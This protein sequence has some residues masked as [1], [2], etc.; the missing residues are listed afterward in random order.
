MAGAPRGRELQFD[1]TRQPL[2][3]IVEECNPFAVRR[4]NAGIS[5][6]ACALRLRQGDDLD[7][8]I[9]KRPLVPGAVE[10]SGPSR[11]TTISM[12]GCVWFNA[13]FTAPTTRLG[14]LRVGMTALTNDLSLTHAAPPPGGNLLFSRFHQLFGTT[15]WFSPVRL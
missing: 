15:T 9:G 3:I 2:I 8:R 11:T 10:S 7:A 6:C 5:G 12:S 13:V 14:R 4:L 1:L